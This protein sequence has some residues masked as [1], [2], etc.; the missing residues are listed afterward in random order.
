[1]DD[2]RLIKLNI[3]LPNCDI[4]FLNNINIMII[5][6]IIILVLIVL[7]LYLLKKLLSWKN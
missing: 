5:L 4:Q 1:M 3:N 2:L 6:I 7:N